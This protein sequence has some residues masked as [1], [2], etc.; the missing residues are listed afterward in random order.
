[1]LKLESQV[2]GMHQTIMDRIDIERKNLNKLFQKGQEKLENR[3]G[4]LTVEMLKRIDD[5]VEK[6]RV[7]FS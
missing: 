1:M 5:H 7:Q 3:F 2:A 6:L 4:D